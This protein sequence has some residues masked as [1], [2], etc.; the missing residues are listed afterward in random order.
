MRDRGQQRGAQPVAFGR[1]I[2]FCRILDGKRPLDGDRGLLDDRLQRGVGRL[3][4]GLIGIAGF[5][6]DDGENSSRRDQ[7]AKLEASRR[8]CR[9]RPPR[10]L[11][12]LEGPSRRRPIGIRELV[13]RW[14]GPGQGEIAAIVQ[15]HDALALHGRGALIGEQP[16]DIVELGRTR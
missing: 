16:D 13:V 3:R 9:R 5:D 15:Q 6:A 4:D 10:R 12:R 1:R 8:Q 2:G 7:R 14:P 11:T